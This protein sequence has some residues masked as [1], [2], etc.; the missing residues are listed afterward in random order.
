MNTKLKP[1]GKPSPTTDITTR[2]LKL[3]SKADSRIIVLRGLV[4]LSLFVAAG[5]CGAINYITLTKNE[6]N[7]AASQYKSISIQALD[8]ISGN[9]GRMNLGSAM[10]AKAYSYANSDFSKW[11]FVSLDG[12]MDMATQLG[13]MASLDNVLVTPVVQLSQRDQFIDHMREVWANE[14]LMP[15][16]TGTPQSVLG[17]WSMGETSPYP[18]FDGKVYA[19]PTKYD[20][21]LVPAFQ[22]TFSDDITPFV[23]GM[24]SHTNPLFG[25]YID[26]VMDCVG[27]SVDI[28]SAQRNCAKVSDI[29]PLPVPTAEVPFPVTTDL[30]AFITN[31]ILLLNPDTNETVVVATV[32]SAVNWQTVLS[33]AVPRY[34]SGVDCVVHTSTASFTYTMVNGVPVFRG[35]GDRH[36]ENYDEYVESIDLLAESQVT[37][38]TEYTLSFYPNSVFFEVYETKTPLYTTIGVICIIIFCLLIFAAYDVAT[39]NESTR[40]EVVLDTKRRFVRFI[41]HEIRTPLNTVRL[42]LKLLEMELEAMSKQVLLTPS[43]EL[44]GMISHTVTSWVQ[45]TD[46][47]LGNSDSAVDVLNDLLNYDKIEMGTLRLEYSSV[48]IWNLVKKTS[49]AFIMQAKQ[50]GIDLVLQGDAWRTGIDFDE[51]A[52]YEQLRVVGDCTRIAQ[53]LRNL[54]SNALKF[55]PEAGLVTIRG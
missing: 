45:L 37:S 27:E 54:I 40:K 55:T 12:F 17:I 6:E 4:V 7:F 38:S 49:A 34:V 8:V 20:N 5:V 52:N 16:L 26:A 32:S 36:D 39:S 2:M 10:L 14:P 31:P 44:P 15:D 29:V 21:I 22:V 3:L 25:P 50:K 51:V 13:V 46:D 11:P 43:S 53:V 9:F 1:L 28:N 18:D 35:V 19:F 47:I 48:A 33:R 23:L 30:Q 42:G 41:S 24:N